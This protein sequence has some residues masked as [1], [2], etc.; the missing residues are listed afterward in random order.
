MATVKK[1]SKINF[2]KFVDTKDVSGKTEDAVVARSIYSNTE[3]VNN[4]GETL[5]GIASSVQ[6]IKTIQL[7]RLTELQNQREKFKAVYT[8]KDNKGV[9]FNFLTNVAKGGVK[10]FWESIV[11]MLSGLFKLFVALPILKWI[12]DPRNQKALAN[13]IKIATSIIKFIAGVAKFGLTNTIDGLYALLSDETSWWEKIVGFGKVVLGLGTLLIALP[14]LL[15]PA[16]LIKGIYSSIRA[17]VAFVS[18]R[19]L[20]GGRGIPITGGRRGRGRGWGGFLTNTLAVGGTVGLGMWG[21]NALTGDESGDDFGAA[22]GGR[23]TFNSGKTWGGFSDGTQPNK[24]NNILIDEWGFT[25]GDQGILGIDNGKPVLV[26]GQDKTGDDNFF[27][28]FLSNINDPGERKK[29]FETLTDVLNNKKPLSSIGIN[30]DNLIDPKLVESIRGIDKNLKTIFTDNELPSSW[31]KSLDSFEEQFVESPLAKGIKGITSFFGN[32]GKTQTKTITT[33]ESSSSKDLPL[34]LQKW[35]FRSTPKDKDYKHWGPEGGE[36]ANKTGGGFF[37]N[38][39]SGA[40]NLLGGIFK[41]YGGEFEKG[42]TIPSLNEGGVISGPDSGYNVDVAGTTITAHGT[43]WVGVKNNG[44]GYVVPLDNRATRNNPHLTSQRADEAKRQGYGAPPGYFLGG[45]ISGVKNIFGGNKE[46]NITKMPFGGGKTKDESRW[47]QKLP[48]LGGKKEQPKPA[49]APKQGGGIGSL[50]SG[51][52]GSLGGGGQSQPQ[53]QQSFNPFGKLGGVLEGLKT[54]IGGWFNNLGGLAG[55][56][57]LMIPGMGSVVLGEKATEVPQFE[58]QRVEQP[59]PFGGVGGWLKNTWNN[60]TQGVS[61]AVSGITDFFAGKDPEKEGMRAADITIPTSEGGEATAEEYRIAA[62][63]STEAG[64][65]VSAT[66]VLQVAANRIKSG[67]YGGND[68]TSIFGEPGQ[69]AGVYDRGV[70]QYKAIKTLDDAVKWSGKTPDEIKG[71]LDDIRNKRYRDASAQFVGGALEFRAAPQYYL[72]RGIVQG[73]MGQ[74]GKFYD[75]KWRGGIWDNQFLIGPQDP[76]I[77]SAATIQ[78]GGISSGG[79]GNVSSAP[80]STEHKSWTGGR[81]PGSGGSWAGFTDG[82]TSGRTIGASDRSSGGAQ[83]G[84]DSKKEVASIKRISDKRNDARAKIN[85][86]TQQM[87]QEALNQIALSNQYNQQIIRDAH[88]TISN[89][90]LAGSQRQTQFISTGGGTQVA[91]TASQMNSNQNVMKST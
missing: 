32:F 62:A 27:Q 79:G 58:A 19:G 46:S 78:L 72:D 88:A 25:K 28:K 9:G 17:L 43:E 30:A 13:G 67:N 55:K 15:N 50:F 56:A 12:Q 47:W 21:I 42:G 54:G 37:G 53:P 51:L 23:P 59:D 8:K 39:V 86:S 20:R 82:T 64:R 90:Q 85:K 40:K 1:G 84:G 36:S 11:G 31:Q 81:T 74:D 5:N 75:S 6:S 4:L 35:I 10:G 70:G 71:Y 45:L 73:Q 48:F 49:P 3:A 24:N 16:K 66:D 26:T 22:D 87:V 76:T 91:S 7:N 57:T 69:F 29:N 80:S 89:L 14:Y 33:T 2:Y 18:T 41:E 52:L 34:D 63:L 83:A 68:F 44:T 77:G 61:G 65:G 38:L 60:L